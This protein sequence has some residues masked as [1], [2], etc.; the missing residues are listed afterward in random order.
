MNGLVAGPLRCRSTLRTRDLIWLYFSNI[1]AVLGTLGLATPWATL[2]MARYRAQNL[3]LVGHAS[4]A[5]FVGAPASDSRAAGSE[6]SDLYDVD[7][8]L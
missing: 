5:E 7:V 4:P 6:A 2:R 8:S 1:F 3:Y